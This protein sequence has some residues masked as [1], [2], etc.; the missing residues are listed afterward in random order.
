MLVVPMTLLNWALNAFLIGLG[1]YLGKLYTS[2]LV[3]SYGKGSLGILI[4]FLISAVVGIGA[5]YIPQSLK[6]QELNLLRGWIQTLDS[7]AGQNLPMQPTE[8]ST[9]HDQA[10]GRDETQRSSNTFPQST[11]ERRDGRTRYVVGN[12]VV[13]R[14]KEEIKSNNSDLMRLIG[15]EDLLLS[16][17]RRGHEF[18]AGYEEQI[19]SAE[20]PTVTS[21]SQ[22]IRSALIDLVKAQEESFRAS[23]RVLEAFDA[24]SEANLRLHS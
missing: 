16:A 11:H 5:F 18:T 7:L 12:D 3:P 13:E 15:R 4:S 19:E 24:I 6:Q 8:G 9:G 23:S 17:K 10:N 20:H 21:P 2:K 22:S 1:I 14:D